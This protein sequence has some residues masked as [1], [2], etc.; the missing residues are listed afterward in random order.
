[1]MMDK[2]ERPSNINCDLLLSEHLEV[3]SVRLNCGQK[4]DC[5][6]VEY[7]VPLLIGL[8]PKVLM[9]LDL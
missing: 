3:A 9:V 8:W 5:A 4:L 1:M 7:S 2:V 6:F